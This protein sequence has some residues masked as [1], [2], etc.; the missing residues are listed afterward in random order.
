ML[1]FVQILSDNI[2]KAAVKVVGVFFAIF[3]INLI[4]LNHVITV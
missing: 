2:N 4:N 3:A 1:D